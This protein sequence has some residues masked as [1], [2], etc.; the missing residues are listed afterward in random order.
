MF[1]AHFILKFPPRYCLY[2]VR[3]Y[4]YFYDNSGK[5]KYFSMKGI[6]DIKHDMPILFKYPASKYL[7]Q[8]QAKEK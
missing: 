6:T 1:F 8:F 3:D 4:S 5:K 7:G 2:K